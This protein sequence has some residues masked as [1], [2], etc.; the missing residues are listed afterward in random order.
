MI[1]EFN[2]A[3]LIGFFEVAP[4]PEPAEEREFFAAPKF[5]KRVG[6]LVLDCSLSLH[7]A[8]LILTLHAAGVSDAVLDL[9][10]DHIQAVSIEHA[11]NGRSWLRVRS[12]SGGV[13]EICVAP[14]ISV[15]YASPP[16]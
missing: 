6:D 15:R 14:T 4:E 11:S 7:F 10:V 2:E 16:A 3:D 5:R 1:T 8:D 12:A 9:R 13:V